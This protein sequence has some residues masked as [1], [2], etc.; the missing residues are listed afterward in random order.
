MVMRKFSVKGLGYEDLR[1]AHN[2]AAPR[3]PR[4]VVHVYIYI[5]KRTYMHI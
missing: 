5:Y 1:L 2:V 3:G 4:D